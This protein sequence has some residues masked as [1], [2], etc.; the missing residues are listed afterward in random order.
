MTADDAQKRTVALMLDC[1]DYYRQRASTIRH[2]SQESGW[3][4][5]YDAEADRCE[6]KAKEWQDHPIRRV[7]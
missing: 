3:T 7:L 5:H 1:A 6:A 2:D 4:Q